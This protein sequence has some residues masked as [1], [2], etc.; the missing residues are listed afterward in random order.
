MPPYLF[1]ATRQSQNTKEIY[2]FDIETYDKNKKFYCGSVSSKK[3]TETFFSKNDII[4]HFKEKR[5]QN[6]IIAASNL[7]FDF[8]GTF[9]N[10][11]DVRHFNI[12]FRG[13]DLIYA[14]TY[15]KNREFCRYFKNNA[16]PLWFIDTMNYAKLSVTNLGKIL[17]LPKLKKPSCI[18]RLPKNKAEKKEIVTYN[19]R[20]SE[21]S[22][23]ALEFLYNSFHSLGATPKLTIASTAMSL[24]KNR[25]L[26]DA[27]FLH[28][29][30]LLEDLFKGYHGGRVEAVSRGFIRSYNYGDINSLYPSVM[31]GEFP[32]PNSVRISYKNDTS[33]IYN[34]EGS[35]LI[36]IHC[37]IMKYPLLP[38]VIPF[39]D[40]FK[41]IFGYGVMEG[42]YNHNEIRK[43]VSLG[44]TIMKVKKTIYYK[45]TCFPFDN[46]VKELYSL[47]LQYKKEGNPMQLVVKLLLNSLYGKFCQRYDNKDNWIPLPDK[48]EEINKL[49]IIE[50]RNNYVRI[51]QETPPRPFCIP[52]WGSY[53]T[54]KARL[55]LY[56]LIQLYNPI[57]YDTD[58]IITDNSIEN[59]T[60]IGRLKK[61]YTIKEGIIVKPK[62][63]GFI[64]TD[65]KEI[66]RCKGLGIRMGY[67]QF[68]D[69]LK[70]P[71]IEYKKFV[72]FKEGLRRDL[73]P[74]E[75][76]S[77][78]KE[79][80]LEDSKR[81]WKSTFNFREMQNSG[82]LEISKDLVKVF[83]AI[84]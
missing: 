17:N 79:F 45:E 53:I 58:S 66:V 55:R 43:A 71:S 83:S 9:F 61:E 82:P 28:R 12:L 59:S 77:V 52:I 10:N 23:E 80:S 38:A 16:R 14:K 42:W 33:F 51:K 4:R 35:S 84:I 6:S 81:Y 46:Y 64:T 31:L 70:K 49:N 68:V 62:W 7:S 20:D 26:K 37:P 76:I 54:S 75:I 78:I 72:K 74:N 27:Y 15:I 56:E 11:D 63:Y 65:N 25:F 8:F 47:R 57:Y 24:Y 32:D 21:I 69:F 29:R 18:G 73:L 22:R 2:G 60:Q 41:L 3:G 30:E 5:F 39:G 34:F 48:I 40:S 50:R 13:S 44:Y 1:K 67:D 36:K 19:R